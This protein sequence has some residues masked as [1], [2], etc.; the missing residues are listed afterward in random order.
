MMPGETK[1]SGAPLEPCDFCDHTEFPL[2]VMSTPAGYYVGTQCGK[3]GAPESRETDYYRTC[4][5]AEA[6][7]ARIKNGDLSETRAWK[8]GK[9]P[10]V[11]T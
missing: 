7:L 11:W 5:E 9:I 6:V 3:C 1:F 8:S 2:R 4:E 10:G